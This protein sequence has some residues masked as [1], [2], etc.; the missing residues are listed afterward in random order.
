LCTESAP[1]RC[2]GEVY[3]GGALVTACQEIACEREAEPWVIVVDLGTIAVALSLCAEH[4]HELLGQFREVE[5][6]VLRLI[7]ER[8]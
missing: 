8:S 3:R 2:W 4:E 5:R 6:A 1:S 7:E